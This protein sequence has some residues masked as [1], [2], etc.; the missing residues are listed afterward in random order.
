[1]FSFRG[2]LGLGVAVLAAFAFILGCDR[3]PEPPS[4]ATSSATAPDLPREGIGAQGGTDVTGQPGRSSRQPSDDRPTI[5]AFGDSL[6]AGLGVSPEDSYPAQL[7]RRLDDAGYRYRV[8]NAGVSGDTSAGGVRRLE[9]VLKSHPRIVIIEIGG[10][11]G[12]RGLDIQQTRANLGEII[13]RFQAAG[14]TVVLA[15]MQ[16]PP[17]YGKD[18][19]AQFA[20]LYP[21]LARVHRLTLIPFFL[22]G[23]AAHPPLNQADGIHP[24][25]AGYH[26]IA[27]TVMKYLSPHVAADTGGSARLAG[28]KKH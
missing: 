11:D 4:G 27:A 8:L 19:T 13:S 18:Y 9:W 2:P 7:Q 25:E 28:R 17:N 24:T 5:V 12:L 20:A 16:L 23:V 14:V 1:M 15:G 3:S 21:E 26:M 6:T 22:E 10:N